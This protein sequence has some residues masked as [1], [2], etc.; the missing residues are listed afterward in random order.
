M[1]QKTCYQC[2]EELPLSEFAFR[3]KKK[4][5]YASMCKNCQKKYNKEWYKKNKE[6]V[7]KDVSKRKKEIQSFIREYKKELCCEICSENHPACLVFHHID[8]TNKDYN[9]STMGKYGLSKKKIIEEISKCKVLCA[10][11]HRKLH[12]FLRNQT[13]IKDLLKIKTQEWVDKI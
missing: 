3:N 9:V 11:C 6:K 8:N 2:K 4:K 5:L 7:I 13:E 1:K 12:E 10:N